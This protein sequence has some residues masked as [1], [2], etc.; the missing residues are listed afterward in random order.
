MVT[1]DVITH[2]DEGK[3]VRCSYCARPVPHVVVIPLTKQ[4][5]L[6]ERIE[7]SDGAELWLGLCADCV[8]GLHRAIKGGPPS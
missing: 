7:A 2:D 1:F 6:E 5:D 3:Q 4:P 8:D